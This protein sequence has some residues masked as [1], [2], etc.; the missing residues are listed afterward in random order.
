MIED[1]CLKVAAGGGGGDIV[2]VDQYEN[3]ELALE[4]RLGRGAN[5][6]IMYR[7]GEKAPAPWQTGPEFQILDDAGAGLDPTDPH[8]VGALYDLYA[9]FGGQGVAPRRRVQR[10]PHPLSRTAASSTGSTA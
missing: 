7:V 2:T 10:R 4:F 5:S 9:A 6:G 3:F 8:S 1:G